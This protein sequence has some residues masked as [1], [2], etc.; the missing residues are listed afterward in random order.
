[1][2]KIE[3]LQKRLQMHG[4]EATIR[5]SRGNDIDAAC[6]QLKQRHVTVS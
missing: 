3:T 1:M 5:N 2:K 6:G 4:V